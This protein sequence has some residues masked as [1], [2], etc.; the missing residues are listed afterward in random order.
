MSRQER[1]EWDE[2]FR[3][4][5][6]AGDE[7][8]PLLTQLDEYLDAFHDLPA[9]AS[10]ADVPTTRRAMDL[11]CGAGRHA[12]YLAERGWRV[13]ACDISLEGLRTARAFATRRGVDVR[14]FCQDLETIQLPAAHFDLIV[15]FFY[16]Q[17]DLFPQIRT[18]LRPGGLLVHKTYTTDQLRFL[19]RPRHATHMLRPQ[20]LLEA[21]R[22]FRVLVYQETL[23]SR[24]VAQLIAQ[25][26][27]SLPSARA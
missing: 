27:G 19:G 17:R 5:D 9:R 15:C 21:F 2:R 23:R 16:L 18:A 22:D 11:A 1:A 26:P 14:L 20:E 12:V 4:G 6:H 25:K 7:P 8:D 24:G 13:T 3:T 10:E